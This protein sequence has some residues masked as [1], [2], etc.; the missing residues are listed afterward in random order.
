MEETVEVEGTRLGNQ[1][2]GETGWAKQQEAKSHAC[3][4]TWPG[5]GSADTHRHRIEEGGGAGRE[6]SEMLSVGHFSMT[7]THRPVC[8]CVCSSGGAVGCQGQEA[9]AGALAW[10]LELRNLRRAGD[11]GTRLRLTMPSGATMLSAPC[12]EG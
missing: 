7:D 4:L 2:A 1:L 12:G 6:R 9:Q 3:S 11:G 8:P 10:G 5:G